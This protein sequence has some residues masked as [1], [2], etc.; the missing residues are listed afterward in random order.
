MKNTAPRWPPSPIRAKASR[1][2]V[3][4]PL[5]LFRKEVTSPGRAG[6]ADDLARRDDAPDGLPADLRRRRR[7]AGVGSFAKKHGLRADVHIAAQ[8]MTTDRPAP[9]MRTT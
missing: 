5:A 2:A 1:H 4:N 3:N 9:S 7:G 8:A 6:R